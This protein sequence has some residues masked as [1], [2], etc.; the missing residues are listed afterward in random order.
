MAR[1][2]VVDD[3][4]LLRETLRDFLEL[5]GHTV[6]EA[7]D[8]FAAVK[9]CADE[10]PDILITD[11][12]MPFRDGLETIRHARRRHPDVK[13][14]AISGRGGDAVNANL[15]RAEK[16]GADARLNKPFTREQFNQTIATVLDSKAIEAD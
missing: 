11:L 2:L 1:V 8:G 9:I 16:M 5:E 13:V 10:R 6:L 12:V 4:E 15:T 7:E 14:I 3:E